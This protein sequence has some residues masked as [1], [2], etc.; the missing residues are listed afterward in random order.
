V[1]WR[2][3]FLAWQENRWTG[4]VVVLA[5]SAMVLATARMCLRPA[6]LSWSRA[7]EGAALLL[8][9]GLLGGWLANPRDNVEL[10]YLAFFLAG[11]EAGALLLEVLS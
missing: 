2:S 4:L 10:F 9:G 6:P 3:R 7:S 8:L 11:A 1:T 5:M